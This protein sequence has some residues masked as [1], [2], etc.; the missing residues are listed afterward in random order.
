MSSPGPSRSASTPRRFHHFA[1]PRGLYLA[2]IGPVATMMLL[3]AAAQAMP[4][5]IRIT[6]GIVVVFSAYGYW[7]GYLHW[8]E[9]S[10]E[11]VT[12]RAPGRRR[13]IPWSQVRRI[14]RYIPPDRNLAA[15]YLYI[16][17]TDA[18]PTARTDPNT[19][20]LQDR[21]DLLEILLAEWRKHTDSA[22]PSAGNG[23]C[24]PHTPAVD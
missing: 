7:R 11:G 2:V 1:A 16:S 21:G 23:A 18:L 14:G 20:Q 9:V 13:H 4:G 6:A 15:Q 22:S 24:Q 10:S 3:V 12:A 17:T 19:I 5:W 8:V